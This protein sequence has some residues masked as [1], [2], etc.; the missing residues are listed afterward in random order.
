MTW[1]Y[2]DIMP[3]GIKYNI[4]IF[5]YSNWGIR[6][7]FFKTIWESMGMR[8][9][10]GMHCRKESDE[11]YLAK[12]LCISE[13]ASWDTLGHGHDSPCWSMCT[14]HG[15]YCYHEWYTHF[16]HWMWGVLLRPG[17]EGIPSVESAHYPGRNT[18]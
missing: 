1:E 8:A 12:T 11:E 7:R 18:K 14:Q 13:I 10:A 2:K 15:E 6:S 4:I 9:N 5:P 17:M 3:L 16:P